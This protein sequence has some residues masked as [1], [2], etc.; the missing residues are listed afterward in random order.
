M[1]RSAISRNFG[2]FAH[3]Y[4]ANARLQL[5]VAEE[6]VKQAGRLNGAV[7]DIGAGPGI[8]DRFSEWDMTA[9]DLSPEMCVLNS[10][11][12]VAGDMH[13]LPFKDDAFDNVVSSLCL[14]WTDDT[15]LV[16]EEVR[17]VVKRGGKF[18]FSIF[19]PDSLKDLRDAFA[20]IDSDEHI[21]NFEHAIRIFAMLKKSGFENIVMNSQK[22]SYH[23][24]NMLE[25]LRSIKNIG[26]SYAYSKGNG[27]RGRKYFTRLENAYK[28]IT[29]NENG[30]VLNWE[31]LYIKCEKS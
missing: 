19:A 3:N 21:M 8:I 27:L 1:D 9:L 13:D 20:Y 5:R 24:P 6:L 25:A 4:E 14:Q 16:L 29:K 26:A 30:V 28:A 11:P 12:A 23:Y 10:T 17:R 2:R 18:V 22:I 15:E 31:V 7:L